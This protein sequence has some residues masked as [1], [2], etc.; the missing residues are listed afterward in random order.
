M[1]IKTSTHR[2]ERNNPVSVLENQVLKLNKNWQPVDFITV[3][4]AVCIAISD[5]AFV[6]EPESMYPTPFTEWM[7]HTPETLK[8][9][10]WIKTSSGQ[11]AAPEIILLKE[12][13]E[14][15]PRRIGFTRPNLAKRDAYECQYCGKYLLLSEVTID[16]VIPRSKGGA[17]H[18]EN[19]VAACE[20]CN[21]RKADQTLKEARMRLR[22]QPH[23]PQWKHTLPVPSGDRFR[24][25]WRPF[26]KE[27]V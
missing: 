14:L 21:S 19:V 8:N 1:G 25:S 6:L 7:E 12:Y 24:Q 11:V 16:H 13:G 15:P 4:D 3:Q 9:H 2:S 10:E 26:I 17:N 23:L 27:A 20:S 18:W 22:K 5:Q